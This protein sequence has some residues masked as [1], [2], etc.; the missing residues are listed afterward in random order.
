[1]ERLMS[2]VYLPMQERSAIADAI[3][4][5]RNVGV[6]MSGPILNDRVVL[7]AGGFNNWLDKDE[8]N[9]FSDNSI[10]YVGRA[11][12]V[13]WENENRNNLLHLGLGYR[14][15]S[16]EEDVGVRTEPEIVQSPSPA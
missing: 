12:W 11:T 3:L 15:S 13:P 10:N 16:A 5:S 9:S 8:P 4:P 14:Y 1:M 2:M 6:V 7:A